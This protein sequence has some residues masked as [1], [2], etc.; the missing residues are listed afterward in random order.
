M[1]GIAYGLTLAEAAEQFIQEVFATPNTVVLQRSF[2]GLFIR[3]GTGDDDPVVAGEHRYE[4]T[5]V[6]GT[7]DDDSLF[8]TGR[9]VEIPFQ[10]VDPAFHF[11]WRNG[12][13]PQH[14]L[15]LQTMVNH[16]DVERGSH[17][18]E[19]TRKIGNGCLYAG[20]CRGGV[21]SALG[22]VVVEVPDVSRIEAARRQGGVNAVG[23]LV[24]GEQPPQVV[25]VQFSLDNDGVS[26]GGA[27]EK[28][29]HQR[30]A[31]VERSGPVKLRLYLIGTL[32][33]EGCAGPGEAAVRS[34]G[35]ALRRFALVRCGDTDGDSLAGSG[36]CIAGVV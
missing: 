34:R 6:A 5:G 16:N 22:S 2:V 13:P 28:R 24:V 30:F 12:F 1:E 19:F 20:F 32:V 17:V 14:E 11:G 8:L 4:A 31:L 27:Y 3:G 18:I 15:I 35:H 21:D 7:H 29:Q 25:G 9:A 10:G 36:E 33:G 23:G 26:G